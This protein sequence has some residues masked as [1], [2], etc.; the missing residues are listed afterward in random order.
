[1]RTSFENENSL[2]DVPFVPE[3]VDAVLR[4]LKPGKA[5][6]HDEVQAEH[7]KLWS[8]FQGLDSANL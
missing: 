4:K 3:E 6:G 5:A 1:M 2:L 7:L 8:H